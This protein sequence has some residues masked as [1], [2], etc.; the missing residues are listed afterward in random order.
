MT[1]AVPPA[2]RP[3]SAV[4]AFDPWMESNPSPGKMH[5]LLSDEE[6]ARLAVIASVVRFRKGAG[7]YGEGDNADAVFNIISGVAKACHRDASGAEDI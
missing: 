7:I 6:R 1:I 5:Q 3:G 4:R 2:G